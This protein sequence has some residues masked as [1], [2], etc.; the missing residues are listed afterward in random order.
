MSKQVLTVDGDTID[1][2][3][4]RQ[5]GK[6][7]DDTEDQVYLINPGLT[8]YGVILPA[9]IEIKIPDHAPAVAKKRRSVFD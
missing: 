3:L 1:G 6:Y 9:G 4:F 2:L 8:S 5:L 7:S